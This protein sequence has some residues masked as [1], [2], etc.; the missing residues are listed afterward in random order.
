MKEKMP[1][2]PEKRPNESILAVALVLLLIFEVILITVVLVRSFRDAKSPITEPPAEET[3]E[4]KEEETEPKPSI[5]VFAG[6][7]L[8]TKPT[9]TEHTQTPEGLSS[10]Y[11]V[12]VHAQTGEILASVDGDARFAPAS[13][14]KVMTLIVACE[15]LSRDDLNRRIPYT[16]EI[17]D[18][19][20]SGHY[21]GTEPLLGGG[22]DNYTKYLDD[23]FRIEDLLYGIG[24]ASSAE[25]TYM[26]CRDVSGSEEAFVVLMNQKAQE[27][28][29]MGTHF[30]NAIGYESEN[31]YTTASDMAAIM[32]YALQC[33]LI[34]NIL[35]QK[36]V[37]TYRAY[38]KENGVEKSY[39][40][41]FNATL[42]DRLS[43]YQTAFGSAYSGVNAT[44]QGGKTG[45]LKENGVVNNCLVAWA[46]S[47]TDGA[48]Y[49]VVL[50]CNENT[51]AYT[52]KDL[53][54]LLDTY[55]S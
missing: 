36:T 33:D 23:E 49:V 41:Q 17:F 34:R 18:Y 3:T 54:V 29:L 31:N 45:Y 30:D 9:V 15:Q 6:G 52:M 5:P 50:G 44:L 8:A 43:S 7:A 16:Q 20:S 13:M 12:L 40:R 48:L 32:T 1:R 38:Y 22:V 21:K 47:K 19:T 26:I 53:K 10:K 37:Y 11:A 51:S 14:T 35:S 2:E 4:K 24:V 28:G 39:G 27:M 55:V 25:C 42:G 46:A